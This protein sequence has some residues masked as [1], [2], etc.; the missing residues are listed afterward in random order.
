MEEHVKQQIEKYVTDKYTVEQ[1]RIGQDNEA[2]R[3]TLPQRGRGNGAYS[4][5]ADDRY[6]KL[7]IEMINSWAR[8]MGEI[9]I[10]AY[11][12]YG[13][14]LDDQILAEVKKIRDTAVGAVS[15]SVKFQMKLERGRGV[16]HIEHGKAIAASFQRQLMVGTQY[17]DR[18]VRCLIEERRAMPKNGN[19]SIGSITMN[20]PG[21]RVV[22]GVDQSHNS[23]TISERTFFT[24]VDQ[25]VRVQIP[26]ELQP[27]ILERLAA[28]EAAVNKPDF[29]QSWREFRSAA[30]DYWSF[31]L[32]YL[33]MIQDFLHRHGITLT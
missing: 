10:K 27:E 7:Y 12:L 16:R 4:T 5:Y 29:A 18:E 30:A 2:K 11:E 3:A 9:R 33:P 17:V 15:G 24:Q 14:P 22:I 8:A 28:V 23:L 21:Q 31:I 19:T 20:A 32:P 26:S 1:Q 25:I 13:V 6:V